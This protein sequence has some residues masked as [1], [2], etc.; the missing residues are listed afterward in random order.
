VLLLTWFGCAGSEGKDGDPPPVET[1][2]GCIVAEAMPAD[3]ADWGGPTE[4]EVLARVAA[5]LPTTIAWT[6]TLSVAS[7]PVSVVATRTAEPARVLTY[8]EFN[9]DDP[10]AECSV[11]P[12]LT[13]PMSFLVNIDDEGVTATVEG[14]F[15]IEAGDDTLHVTAEGP[16]TLRREWATQAEDEFASWYDGTPPERGDLVALYDKWPVVGVEINATDFPRRRV[17]VLWRGTFT[18]PIP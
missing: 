16:A 11:V 9:P 6:S 15:A 8:E 13:L 12:Q 18:A 14:D 4:Q 2:H 17:S 7:S 1:V 10:I 5:S 3:E